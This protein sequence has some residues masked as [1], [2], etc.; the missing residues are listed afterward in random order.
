MYPH[1]IFHNNKNENKK[2]T[3]PEQHY[4]A[5][6]TTAKRKIQCVTIA[7]KK[8]NKLAKIVSSWHTAPPRFSFLENTF[9][10]VNGKWEKKMGNPHRTPNG[11][12]NMDT[13]HTLDT[14]L[15]YFYLFFFCQFNNILTMIFAESSQKEP[16]NHFFFLCSFFSSSYIMWYIIYVVQH[17]IGWWFFFFFFLCW[18][19]SLFQI[20]KFITQNIYALSTQF[21]CVRRTNTENTSDRRQ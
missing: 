18:G 5:K 11:G 10:C 13:Q 8:E 7:K 4:F 2:N 17:Y 9:I 12:P 19:F 6:L 20:G 3:T 1:N 21:F 15:Y 14:L 16:Q